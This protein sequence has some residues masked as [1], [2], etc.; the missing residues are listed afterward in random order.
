MGNRT[1]IEYFAN[2]YNKYDKNKM[3]EYDEQK[4][5]TKILT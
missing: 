5:V 4:K 3:T 1:S 2:K